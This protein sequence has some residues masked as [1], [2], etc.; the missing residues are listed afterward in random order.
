MDV[1][2]VKVAPDG[3]QVLW[4]TWLGG[5]GNE[6]QALSIR[7]DAEEYVYLGFSTQ[8]NDMPTTPGAFGRSYNGGGDFFVAKLNPTGS[9][10]IF[11]TYLGG[12]GGEWISTHNLALD[13]QGNVYASTWTSSLDYPTTPGAIQ[14]IYGGGNS[15][16]AVSKF[17]PTG[18]L[19]ASTYLGGAG[20]EN[21]DGIYADA[22]GNLF[23]TGDTS[24]SNLPVTVNAWQTYSGGGHDAVIALLSPDLTTL[25]YS[26]YLGGP[27][28]D[29]GRSG[30]L[31]E[32]GSL[33]VTGSTDGAGWPTQDAQQDTFAGG[34]GEWGAGDC[35]LAKFTHN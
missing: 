1:G 17:S 16:I 26:T 4:A 15:D 19:L 23:L 5:S 30:F 8:S 24:A 34:P 10:L 3:S 21:P 33:Y 28:Y 13:D 6:N 20:D 14:T 7:V 25:L 2:A 35:I 12:S 32:D 11:G 9:D 22:S 18:A 31:G 27:S 29:N